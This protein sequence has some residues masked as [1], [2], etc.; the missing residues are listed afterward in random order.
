MTLLKLIMGQQIIL[1]NNGIE[2]EIKGKCKSEKA[3]ETA[4]IESVEQC[5]NKMNSL[6]YNE[7]LIMENNNEKTNNDT[8][9]N[10][11]K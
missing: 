1:N 2:N 7:K 9:N 4:N 8:I 3:Q 10:D 11:I 6:D 5:S